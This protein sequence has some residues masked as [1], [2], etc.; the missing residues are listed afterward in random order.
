MSEINKDLLN[1]SDFEI[2]PELEQLF[3]KSNTPLGLIKEMK[4]IGFSSAKNFFKTIVFVVLLNLF[5]LFLSFYFVF[6]QWVTSSKILYVILIFIIGF[7]FI[8]YV[9][10]KLYQLIRID[11][12]RY[13]FQQFKPLVRKIS[14]VII[15]RSEEKINGFLNINEIERIITNYTSK[16]PVIFKNALIFVLRRIPAMSFV[17]EV[18]NNNS[19]STTEQRSAF[20]NDKINSYVSNTLEE[21]KKS[22]WF[23]WTITINVI[24]QLFFVYLIYK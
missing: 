3:K 5:F 11:F 24:L 15:L 20:L 14:D 19:L 7:V 22:K 9:I 10:Y 8:I 21:R 16:V 6:N 18:Y 4:N 23:V 1:E 12:G 17:M 2:N 13:V